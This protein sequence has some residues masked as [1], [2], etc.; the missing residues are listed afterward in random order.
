MRKRP[1]IRVITFLTAAVVVVG[2]FAFMTHRRAE[3]LERYA[4]A[5]TE[6]AFEELVTSVGELSNA[7]EKSVYISDPALES[8]LCTQIFGRA[9]TA[10]MAMGTLPYAS[11]DLERTASFVAK[12]GDYA[13]TLART[14]GGNGG[15]SDEELGNLRSLAETAAIM[16]LNLEDLQRRIACGE[17]TLEDLYR[18]DNGGEEGTPDGV[19]LAGTAIQTIEGEF[20]ELPTLI[21]DGPFSQA[22]TGKKPVFLTGKAMVNQTAAQQ[23]AAEF[24]DVDVED[25]QAQGE[26]G[27]DVPCWRYSA[28]VNG[29]AYTVYVT[30][31]G[32]E[33]YTVICSRPVGAAKCSVDEGLSMTRD[34]LE[35][36]GLEGLEESY[37]MV[38]N[39]VLL[40]NYAFA[41]DDVICY[42]D[43]I[44]VGVALDNGELMSYDAQGYIA[45]HTQRDIPEAALSANDAQSAL[46]TSLNV[47]GHNLAI[48]PSQGGEERFCHEFVCETEAGDHYILYVNALTGAEEKIL[49]LL[50]DDSGALTI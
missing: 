42:P 19:P 38:E 20:P 41:Q 1:T 29:G 18:A 50:E 28:P 25:M 4:R 11:Q 47:T 34:L 17:L 33:V 12:V 48:I 39:G 27:G 22:L 37:H 10:Q 2:A 40:V 49:I 9:M 45:A 46:S 31:Q 14:V 7:L 44:K 21:Y 8:A 43:L 13:C 6:H 16:K 30:K 24:L 35:A 32:G 5:N 15:Y 3:S 26:C 36:W 23:A